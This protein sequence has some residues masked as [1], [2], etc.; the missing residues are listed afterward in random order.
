MIRIEIDKNNR[1]FRNFHVNKIFKTIKQLLA[2]ELY[3]FPKAQEYNILLWVYFNLFKILMSSTSELRGIIQEYNSELEHN[4]PLIK[5]TIADYKNKKYINH[6]D[7]KKICIENSLEGS[8][9]T[10]QKCITLIENHLDLNTHKSISIIK[11]MKTKILNKILE[12]IFLNFYSST[13]D[14]PK[15][16]KNYDRYDFVAKHRLKTCPYCNMGY[17]LI[18]KD[19]NKKKG[20]RPDIDHF[21]PKSIYPY[22]AMSFYNLI[23]SCVVCNRTKGSKDTFKDELLSPYEIDNNA[24]K[25]TYRPSKVNFNQVQKRH[26]K[27][28][29]FSIEV[30]TNDENSN[31]YFKLDKLYIQHKDI[32]QELLI[33]KTIYTKS[34]I[35]E[36]KKNFYFTD[37]E[38]YRFLLC[39][40]KE[41][42]KFNKRPLSK[43]IRDISEELGLLK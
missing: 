5:L 41:N 35:D 6:E 39:N 30:I 12:K 22:L 3:N 14:N 23:P 13:W 19:K 34:Y 2:Y 24:V 21:F 28:Q 27:F 31:N 1:D 18:G 15:K 9:S 11:K 32:V 4:M 17:I 33:K 43:L 36:L 7:L 10:K 42:D 38:I 25:F 29:T 26:F 16:I 40:Y 20:L 8:L 37:D